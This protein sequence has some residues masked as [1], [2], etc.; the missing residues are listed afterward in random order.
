[1]EIH[2]NQTKNIVNEHPQIAQEMKQELQAKL[3]ALK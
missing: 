2:S 3:K 1:M